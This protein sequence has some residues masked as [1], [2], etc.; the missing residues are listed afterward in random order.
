MRKFNHLN[1]YTRPICRTVRLSLGEQILSTSQWE[2]SDGS[3]ETIEDL[4]DI[5]GED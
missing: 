2:N 1:S 3:T 5:F 4:D